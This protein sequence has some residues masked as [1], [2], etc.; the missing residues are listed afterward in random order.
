MTGT[1]SLLG[2]DLSSL[3]TIYPVIGLPPSDGANHSMS[4]KSR[5][6]STTLGLPGAPG[7]A[8]S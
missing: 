6:A 7:A 2:L 3:S 4:M 5:S 1:Q 8:K